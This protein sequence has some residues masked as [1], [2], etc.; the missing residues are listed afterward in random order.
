MPRRSFLALLCAMA[1]TLSGALQAAAPDIPKPGNKDLCPVCGMLVSK[2]PN[3]IAMVT[4]KDGHAHYFDGA[5]DVFKYL[6]D[7][8]KYAPGHKASDISGI[9]VTEFYGLTKID[10]RKALYVI[11]SDVLGPMGNEFVPLENR[12]DAEDF[13]KEHKGNRIVTFE[14]ATPDMAFKLDKGRFD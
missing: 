9:W 11:G 5:K 6:G 14:Q 10:A 4:Y 12:N 7:L 2:Y 1:I 8:S 3:W 13:L